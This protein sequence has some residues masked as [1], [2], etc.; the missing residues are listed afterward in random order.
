MSAEL[1]ALADRVMACPGVRLGDGVKTLPSEDFPDGLRI[2]SVSECGR[3]VSAYGNS[4]HDGPEVWDLVLPADKAAL[5]PDF[6]DALT[7]GWLLALVREA[8]NV[9]SLQCGHTGGWD[10]DWDTWMVGNPSGRGHGCVIAGT[11]ST[12]AEALVA[13]LEDTP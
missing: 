5:R 12:E 6:S 3:R 11:G 10:Q 1:E 4:H 8:W 7:R 9:P 2:V 13:A